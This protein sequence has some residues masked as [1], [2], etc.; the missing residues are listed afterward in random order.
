MPAE[1]VPAV[2][3]ADAVVPTVETSIAQA[4]EAMPPMTADGAVD[5]EAAAA[6]EATA[7]TKVQEKSDEPAKEA[8]TIDVWRPASVFNT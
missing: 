4:A 3:A 6:T 8:E 7:E 1:D 5:P 2:P